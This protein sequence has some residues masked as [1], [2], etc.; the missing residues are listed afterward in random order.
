MTSEEFDPF[1][2]PPT[3]PEV[4]LTEQLRLATVAKHWALKKFV[5]AEEAA[6]EARER[7]EHLEAALLEAY[8]TETDL[9]YRIQKENTQ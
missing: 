1:D 2:V 8:R 7:V 4:P 5:E 6:E 9:R 3:R